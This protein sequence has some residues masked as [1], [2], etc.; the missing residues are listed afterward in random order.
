MESEACALLGLAVPGRLG[1]VSG[2][3]GAV[4]VASGGRGGGQALMDFLE[5]VMNGGL[6]LQVL[7]VQTLDELMR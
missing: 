7:T 3:A 4:H 6:V 2:R 5:F 1:I